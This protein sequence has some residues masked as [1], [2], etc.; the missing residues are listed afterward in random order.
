MGS[1]SMLKWERV[2]VP[3]HRTVSQTSEGGRREKG[4][5]SH[6][7]TEKKKKGR[8]RLHL[9]PTAPTPSRR[10]E[11]KPQSRSSVGW[12]K[13]RLEKERAP[14]LSPAT[15]WNEEEKNIE[16]ARSTRLLLSQLP[17]SS[18]KK[19][20]GRAPFVRHLVV[21]DL[22]ECEFAQKRGSVVFPGSLKN[23]REMGEG[24]EKRTPLADNLTLIRKITTLLGVKEEV[25]VDQFDRKRKERRKVCVLAPF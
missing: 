14:T 19:E 24:E 25:L 11:K 12:L 16:G 10:T 7:P 5:Y 18:Q 1:L 9:H 23:H 3:G 21:C 20:E 15:S 6:L 8:P 4:P 2:I 22:G 13:G 17:K